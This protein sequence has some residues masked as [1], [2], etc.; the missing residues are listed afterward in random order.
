VLS[1][2]TDTL[3]PLQAALGYE[4]T[5]ALFLDRQM[6]LVEKPA[7]L[8]YLKWFSQRLRELGRTGLARAWTVAPCGG[9]E[10][11]GAFMALFGGNAPTIA[12]LL[13]STTRQEK[14]PALREQEILKNCNVFATPMYA[15]GERGGVEELLGRQT[16]FELVNRCYKLPRRS[17][18][19]PTAG[20]TSYV[21]AVEEVRARFAALGSEIVPFDDYAPAEYLVQTG[22]KLARK[23]PNMGQALDRFEKL[24]V[25][26]NAC[27]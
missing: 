3:I 22:K 1:T 17:R 9:I 21:G 23:L 7:D 15:D 16:Y 14:E 26:V 13:D 20:A 10:K 2:D 4:I 25:D 6:L 19:A 12:V 5:G 18:L 27:L 8:L 11:I 24:F